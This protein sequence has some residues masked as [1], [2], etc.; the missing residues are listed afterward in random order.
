MEPNG[1][2]LFTQF[3][4]NKQKGN[5]PTPLE[6]DDTPEQKYLRLMPQQPQ[7]LSLAQF[8]ADMCKLQCAALASPLTP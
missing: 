5:W 7:S 8:I 1:L 4:Y 2:Y 3:L 6:G